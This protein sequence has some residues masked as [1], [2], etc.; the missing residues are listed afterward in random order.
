MAI[1]VRQSDL[2]SYMR[3][4]KQY[5]F[6]RDGIYPREQSSALSFGTAI[7]DA[8]LEME[9][10]RDLK[11]GLD[12]YKAIW[13]NL[14]AHD[15]AYDYILPR[16]SHEGYQAMAKQILGD[17]WQIIQ[18]DQDVVLGREHFFEVPLGKRGHVLTG[19]VDKLALRMVGSSQVV[20]ISDYKTSAKAP[21]RDYLRH[22]VQFTAYSYASTQPEF[23][24]TIPGGLDIMANVAKH[25][26]VGEWV[27]L[28]GPSASTPARA[29]SAT[30]TGSRWR[31]MHL[32]TPRHSRCS[33][34]TWPEKFVSIA[35]T[36]TP[37]AC[38]RWRR[39]RPSNRHPATSAK[40]AES[41]IRPDEAAHE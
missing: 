34:R 24:G 26:R 12:R 2:S 5:W 7:H 4:P 3:C 28:R 14:E 10:A 23:W 15:L 27:H 11:V 9:V 13:N 25:P 31:S 21:T 41:M 35:P 8:V 38:R 30:T 20:L 32:R 16:N 6:Q 29:F 39:R 36:A 17:W 1:T 22:N 37:A 18:W 19:T 40:K 33:C